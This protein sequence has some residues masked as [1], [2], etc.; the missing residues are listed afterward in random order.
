MKVS[1][2]I[3]TSLNLFAL[4][5]ACITVHAYMAN[6]IL[7]GDIVTGQM[8]DNGRLVCQS[9]KTINGASGNS[10]FTMKC[11]GGYSL[12]F[13]NNINTVNILSHTIAGE[14]HGLMY[15]M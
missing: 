3:I 15:E 10:V 5:Q 14:R 13:T 2:T 9:G 8:Y 6:C 4:S 12:S 7:T 11:D 1:A